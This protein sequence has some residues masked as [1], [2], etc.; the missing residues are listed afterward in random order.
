MRFLKRIGRE[1]IHLARKFETFILNCTERDKNQIVV[2]QI[3]V[4]PVHEINHRAMSTRVKDN[5]VAEMI[6]LDLCDRV[7]R[8]DPRLE[9][10]DNGN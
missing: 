10:T 4:S 8:L 2:L 5:L 7:E 9:R 6:Y 3:S 1:I